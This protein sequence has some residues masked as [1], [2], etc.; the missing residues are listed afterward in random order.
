MSN[1]RILVVKASSASRIGLRCENPTH[2]LNY[3][4]V[5]IFRP[6]PEHCSCHVMS[7]QKQAFYVIEL[8]CFD[9]GEG[10]E[11]CMVGKL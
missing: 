6:W 9:K 3:I 2:G 8:P 5:R 7:R 11:H 1:C 10:C 4:K